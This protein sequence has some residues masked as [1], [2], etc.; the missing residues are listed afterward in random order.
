[1]GNFMGKDGFVWFVGVVED[2]QDPTFTGRV[3]VRCLGYHTEN[4]IKLP[5]EDL[6]WSHVMN[7]VTSATVSGVGQTPLGLVEGSWV[8]GFFRDGGEAQQPVIIG[9]LPGLPASLPQSETEIDEMKE[10]VVAGKS[11][12]TYSK[13]GKKISVP[14]YLGGFQDPYMNYPRYAGEPDVNRLAVNIKVVTDPPAAK[15]VELNPHPSLLMR[16][17]DVDLG[18]ATAS[19]ESSSALGNIQDDQI[20]LYGDTI[21][22]DYGTPWD[23]L[24]IASLGS[25]D[26]F[27]AVYP[28]NHVYESEGGHIREMDDTPGKERIH[29]RHASGSGY[30]IFPDGSK[31]TRVKKDNYSIVTEDDYVHIQGESTKT[32]DGGLRVFIN[33]DRKSPSQFNDDKDGNNYNIQVGAGANVTIQV[34]EGDINLIAPADTGNINMKAGGTIAIESGQGVYLRTKLMDAEVNETWTEIVGGVN[35]KTGSE[36]DMDAG[37]INLN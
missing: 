16:R 2:R 27:T 21:L 25:D 9:S 31:V 17:A 36:I 4:L 12:G 8:M 35:K 34:D 22:Q 26:T 30:E 24:D 5:T 29:E 6:P 33:K 20:G 18:I 3:R 19:I 7:P 10:D 23:E 1:M 32:I 14:N 11:M 37:T 13:T 15:T 28:Y